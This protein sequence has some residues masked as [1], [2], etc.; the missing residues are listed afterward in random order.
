MRL[1][2]NLQEAH[3]DI[4]E[5]IAKNDELKNLLDDKCDR[6]L[7]KDR[8]DAIR[9]LKELQGD[10]HVV[11]TGLSILIFSLINCFF[12]ISLYSDGML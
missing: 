11:Y 9:M 6:C 1:H 3:I 7:V 4:R 5:Q 8:A 12:K 2:Q 10:Y